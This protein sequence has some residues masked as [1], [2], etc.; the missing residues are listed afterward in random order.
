[1]ATKTLKRKAPT[2][3]PKAKAIEQKEDISEEEND[4]ETEEPS[5]N[6][7]WADSI[8]KVLNTNKPKTKKSIVLSKAKKIVPKTKDAT[9]AISFEIDGEIKEEKPDKE[10]IDQQAKKLKNQLLALRVKPSSDEF[11][12]ERALRK[13][14]TR[15]V[16]QLFNAVRLQQKDIDQ[17]LKE[18]GKLDSKREA[19]LNNIDKRKFLD[20]L[21][22]GKRAKSEAIDNP[23]KIE[24]GDDDDDDDDEVDESANKKGWSVL[25]DDFMTNKKIKHWD[26]EESKEEAADGSSGDE[27]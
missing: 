5:G 12:R 16:V 2:A 1:M 10:A 21:M 19:V 14:A 3:N 20:V 7:G 9:D 6:A 27:D 18:A 22:G 11:E 26:E 25:R 4:S 13:I 8:A 17:Q 15:G 23:V 24:G